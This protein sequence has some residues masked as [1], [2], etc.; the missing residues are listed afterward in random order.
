MVGVPA[1][2]ADGVAV[3][4]WF[5]CNQFEPEEASEAKPVKMEFE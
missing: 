3:K 1:D 4:L 2:D 5:G